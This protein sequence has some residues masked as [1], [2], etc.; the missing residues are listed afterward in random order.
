MCRR[1]Q[2]LCNAVCICVKIPLFFM[3][4]IHT[5]AHTVLPS[6]PSQLTILSKTHDTLTIE[7]LVSDKGTTPISEVTVEITDPPT[8]VNKTGAFNLEER[9]TLV[10]LGLEPDTTYTL[11]G[12][13]S[14]AAGRSPVSEETIVSTGVC[15]FVYVC[16]HTS[17]S[18]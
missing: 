9:V 6:R 12:Y 4:E 11:V 3:C 18:C 2:L 16:E 8:L 10:L 7:L 17:V 13:V 14:N 1:F 15:L 5:H